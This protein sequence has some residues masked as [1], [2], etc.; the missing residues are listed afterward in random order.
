MQTITLSKRGGQK[1]RPPIIW[2]TNFFRNVI[3]GKEYDG[4]ESF[5]HMGLHGTLSHDGAFV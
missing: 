4:V 3:V 2:T 1:T 5:T